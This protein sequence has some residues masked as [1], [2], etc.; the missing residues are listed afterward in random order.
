VFDYEDGVLG[1]RASIAPEGGFGF[2]ARHLDFHPTKPWL[3]LS[4]ER[5]N[6][7]QMYQMTGDEI[8]PVP[9]Y[10]RTTLANSGIVRQGQTASTIR[11]HPNGRTVYVGNRAAAMVDIEG[12]PTW[13][14]GENSLAVYSISP[15]TGE[16]TLVQHADTQGMYPRTFAIDASG[17]VLVVGNQVSVPVMDGPRVKTV[18]A[19]LSVFLILGDG[20]LEHAGT[21]PME[22]STGRSLFWV[23]MG[24][25]R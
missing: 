14:G 21:Y 23:G 22:V 18:P 12:T 15:V 7:L 5:Q 25:V 10:T 9:R 4:L 16:P 24:S 11:V 20:T 1:N 19:G 2:Q 6:T 17:R 13:L 8:E 3:F